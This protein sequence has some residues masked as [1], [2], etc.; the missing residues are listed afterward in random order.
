MDWINRTIT[1]HL[2]KT[3]NT[4]S[5]VLITGPRQVGKSSLLQKVRGNFEYITLD[6][7][8]L[9]QQ[10][11]EDP[12]LFLM[13]HPGELIL[14]E[15]QYAPE[16]FPYLKTRIDKMR[17][18]AL[19]DSRPEKCLFLLSG[20]QSYHTME[21]VSESL[22]GRLAILPLQGISCRE[23]K[24]VS[25]TLPFV[26]DD[27]YLSSRGKEPRDMADLWS[28][29]HQGYMPGLIASNQAWETFYSSYVAT[30]IE[31]DVNQL[32]KV[33]E[34]GDF[35]RFMAAVAARSSELL[36]YDSISRDVGVSSATVKRW[37]QIL[38]TS[39]IILQI[40]PYHNNHLKRM[41][42]TPK[43]F[44]MDTGLMAYLTRWI[45]PETIQ[46][47]AK[48]GQF[49]ETWVVSEIVK[50]FLNAGKSVRDLYYYRDVDQK[51]ID[52]VL[53]IGRT[54]YPIEIKM[55]AKPNKSMA[56]AFRLLEPITKA[57]DMQLGDG[58]II[59]QYPEL[60]FL[61]AGIRSIP[62]GYL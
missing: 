36:N 10:A 14:D 20:S 27:E 30:Y 24:N 18:A 21:N 5:A 41:I 33:A 45:T 44:F 56:R 47:G 23:R 29:I 3:I 25:C 48:A 58:A 62:V 50:S 61:E 31:R 28:M 6:D 2:V 37:I 49:F 55:T 8:L 38:E 7:P 53:E 22:A 9:L 43:I 19:K 39:G 46:H 51:E 4:F 26:P 15:I 57:G 35:V 34:K 54:V 1:D 13:N 52:L 42:K 59:N 32:T 11:K 17:F 60:M 16:L 40:Y 12:E